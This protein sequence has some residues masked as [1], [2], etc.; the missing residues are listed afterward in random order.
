MKDVPTYAYRF[1]GTRY[2]CGTP[3]GL[4]LAS[5]ALINPSTSSQVREWLE[6]LGH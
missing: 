4:L 3:M 2:D 1:S 5:L 6:D